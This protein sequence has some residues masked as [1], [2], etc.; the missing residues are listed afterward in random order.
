M[1]RAKLSTMAHRDANHMAVIQVQSS[2]PQLLARQR[3]DL[4]K[5]ETNAV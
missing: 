1:T 5:V 2:D 4:H 3:F